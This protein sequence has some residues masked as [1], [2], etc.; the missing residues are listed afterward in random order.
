MEWELEPAELAAI[1]DEFRSNTLELLRILSTQL[2][3]LERNPRDSA[4]VREMFLCAHTIK[5][6]ASMLGLAAIRDVT[7]AMEDVL[8]ILRDGNRSLGPDLADLLFRALDVVRDLLG[9]TGD[10]S[11]A[12]VAGHELTKALRDWA[13]APPDQS[14][15]G[16]R[17]KVLL[18]ED[19]ATVRAL[20]VMLLSDAGFDVDAVK[21]GQEALA[22]ARTRQYGVVITGGE[23][24]GLRGVELAAALRRLPATLSVP[25]I[26]LSSDDSLDHRQRAAAAGVDAVVPR[27]SLTQHPLLMVI[28]TLMNRVKR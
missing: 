1:M 7:H 16:E 9:E 26:L 17:P 6:G 23:T 15:P 28:Q 11:V 12:Q 19:S 8:A 3:R 18:V 14:L 20:E 2:L 10:S 5:G 27:G 13:S 21:D 24:R 4:P 25:I 22:L